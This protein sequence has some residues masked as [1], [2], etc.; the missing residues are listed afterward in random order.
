MKLLRKDFIHLV[1]DWEEDPEVRSGESDS[2]YWPILG[3]NNSRST[4]YSISLIHFAFIALRGR[5][6]SW[7]VGV[8]EMWVIGEGGCIGIMGGKGRNW[9]LG[10]R[11]ECLKLSATMNHPSP[12]M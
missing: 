9:E 10:N 11:H 7:G 6:K 5:E 1:K 2:G 3:L 12:G 4:H 8:G